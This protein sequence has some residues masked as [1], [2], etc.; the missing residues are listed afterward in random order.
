MRKFS[1]M[2]L[3]LLLVVSSVCFAE[4]EIIEEVPMDVAIVA[5]EEPLSAEPEEIAIPESCGEGETLDCGH[6]EAGE[7]VD[8]LAYSGLDCGHTKG[9]TSHYNDGTQTECCRLPRQEVRKCKQCGLETIKWTYKSNKVHMGPYHYE[10]A[11]IDGV[12][13]R[14]K[15]CDSCG[16]EISKTKI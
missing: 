6:C 4:T 10:D 16:A 3:A 7:G 2:L 13:Y 11:R 1:I 9:Y 5:E 12:D 14:V 8:L 15:Y